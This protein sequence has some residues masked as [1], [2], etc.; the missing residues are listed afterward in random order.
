MYTFRTGKMAPCVVFAQVNPHDTAT[1]VYRNVWGSDRDAFRDHGVASE[2]SIVEQGDGGRA[3]TAASGGALMPNTVALE[4][5]ANIR[6]GAPTNNIANVGA[7]GGSLRF[8]AKIK[9]VGPFGQVANDVLRPCR[10]PEDFSK[11]GEASRPDDYLHPKVLISA[12]STPDVQWRLQVF[13]DELG[14]IPRNSMYSIVPHDNTAIAR[15]ALLGILSSAFASL[16]VADRTATRMINARVIGQL[17]IPTA[18]KW[19]PIASVA[20]RAV[21]L[22]ASG[23]DLTEA[24]HALEETVLDAYAAPRDVRLRIANAFGGI[25]APEGVIRYKPHTVRQPASRPATDLAPGSTVAVANGEV[26]LHVPGH[27]DEDGSWMTLPPGLPGWLAR[28]DSTFVVRGASSGL[29][30]AHYYFQEYSWMTLDDL[31]ADAVNP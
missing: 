19:D 26:K 1:Y 7:S 14:V 16:W 29:A 28:P 21:E 8:L 22:R 18:D 10:Y 12:M 25:K 5:I 2:S 30:Q 31:L 9:D 6:D 20:R 15:F 3:F 11:R 27:T 13:L 17:P 24:V 4:S 23:S